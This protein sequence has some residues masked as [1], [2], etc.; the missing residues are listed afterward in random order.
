MT[1]LRKT[2]PADMCYIMHDA[3]INRMEYHIA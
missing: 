3:Y 1:E 2:R